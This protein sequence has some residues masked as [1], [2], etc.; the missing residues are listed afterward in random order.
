[1][2]NIK[3]IVS[4]AVDLGE[5]RLNKSAGMTSISAFI[6]GLYV[7]FGGL[8]ALSVVAIIS[9][10]TGS[11]QL[12]WFVGSMFYPI[13]FLFVVIG[14]SELFTENFLLPVLSVWEADSKGTHMEIIRLWVFG[15]V[16]NIIGVLVMSYLVYVTGLLSTHANLGTE[17][18]NEVVRVASH[19]LQ[20]P[21]LSM[22]G[23]AIFAGLFINFMSWLIVACED[24][25]SKF[26]IVW[27]TTFP[28][29]LLGT[30]HSIVGSGEILIGI[31]HGAPVTYLEWVKN[32]LVPVALG[33][34]VGGVVFVAALH[35]LKIFIYRLSEPV[36]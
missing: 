30:Y 11:H 6:A 1:M 19:D 17:V 15:F 36:D 10:V 16:F 35:Y 3:S 20:P 5:K 28:I 12:G 21:F 24:S 34:H 8:V 23:K 22:F 26:V 32:F 2:R 4:E 31:M 7:T 14:R 33:N 27:I 13:G 25:F 9:S 29:M 18:V